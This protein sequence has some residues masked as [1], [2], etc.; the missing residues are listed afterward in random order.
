LLIGFYKEII[1]IIRI[2]NNTRRKKQMK[3]IILDADTGIDDA[4]AILY[5]LGSNECELIG[6]TSIYGNVS[7][8]TSVENS[9]SILDLVEHQT[10]PVYNGSEAKLG[11]DTY[12]RREI[13]AEI[14]GHDGIGA[15]HIRKSTR[16]ADS[17]N[18]VD[19]L[20]EASEEHG[21]ELTSVATSPLTNLAKPFTKAPE[22]MTKVGKVVILGGALTV[23]GNVT[24][25]ADANTI[26]DPNA[27]KTIFESGL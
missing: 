24:P 7:V 25:Y 1:Q 11:S 21:S 17:E 23:T 6:I 10:I 8:D 18:A 5:A 12:E 13:T 16:S 2:E 19:C 14:H 22:S 27:A 20:I 4:L 9:L 15:V 26:E 3:K